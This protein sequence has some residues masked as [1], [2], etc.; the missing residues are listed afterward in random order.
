[1]PT[2]WNEMCTF[3]INVNDINYDNIFD[4]DGCDTIT[5]IRLMA[6]YIIFVK[7]KILK[8]DKR[9]L[10]PITWHSKDVGVLVCQKE[11]NR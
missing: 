7:R 1:M 3:N 10:I 5:L 8:K 9:K 11:R 6:W 2:F 4:G